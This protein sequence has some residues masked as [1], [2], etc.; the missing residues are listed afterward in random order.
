M[1]RRC[2]NTPGLGR[3]LGGPDHVSIRSATDAHQEP[4]AGSDLTLIAL[5]EHIASE[6]AIEYVERMVVAADGQVGGLE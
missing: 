3:N 6:L 1:P 4:R 5:L 2:A